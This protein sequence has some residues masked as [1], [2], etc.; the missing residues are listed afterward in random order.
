MSTVGLASFAPST[1][2]PCPTYTTAHGGPV[3][4]VFKLHRWWPLSTSSPDRWHR[5][6]L[7]AVALIRLVITVRVAIAAPACVYAQATVTH[8]LPRAA[9]LVGGCG[10]TIGFCL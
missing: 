1:S 8:E 10:N 4:T 5:P 9:R 3:L 7:T 6:P 2:G